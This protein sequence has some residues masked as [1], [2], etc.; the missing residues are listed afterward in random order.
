M[1]FVVDMKFGVVV[2]REVPAFVC[3]KCGDAWI[4]NPV[5]AKLESVVAEA[6]RTHHGGDHAMEAGGDVRRFNLPLSIDPPMS[7]CSTLPVHCHP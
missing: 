1:T 3:A 4:D 5:A 7:R 2:V 6:R